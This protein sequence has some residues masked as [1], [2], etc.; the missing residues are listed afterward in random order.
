MLPAAL[1][2]TLSQLLPNS[3]APAAPAADPASTPGKFEPEQKVM[4]V[5]Q[6]EVAPGVFKVR[7]ADQSVQM[8]L[9]S[10]V[11]RGDNIELQVIAAHPRLVFGLAPS[12]SP[13]SSADQLSIAA[14]LFSALSQRQPESAM[15]KAKQSAP[16]WAESSPPDTLQLAVRLK[17]TLSQS[18]LFYESHQAQ[19]IEGGRSTAKLLQ[20]P[21]NLPPEQTRLLLDSKV[22][23]ELSHALP[24]VP[25][26]LQAL[27]QQQM[28]ALDTRQILWQGPVWQEQEA[29][30]SIREEEP[31]P[32]QEERAR[33]WV[34][35]IE[36]DLPHLGEVQATLRFSSNGLSLSLDACDAATREL[37]GS[38]SLRLNAALAERGIPINSMLIVQHDA[39]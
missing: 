35:Q 14:R 24:G 27:V 28:N 38:A 23:P 5:I 21:Q 32:G 30:W 20:E 33:Q 7:I 31:P 1:L 2:N 10:T 9:P 12:T 8:R 19:W 39:K 37:M 3:K 17:E 15:L 26:H 25:E 16:L 34:T 22:L 11:Q 4:G 36:L 29:Q 18:G 6:S 13:L